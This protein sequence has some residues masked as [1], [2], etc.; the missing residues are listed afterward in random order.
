MREEPPEKT[1]WN[2][3]RSYESGD[4]YLYRMIFSSNKLSKLRDISYSICQ[5]IIKKS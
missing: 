3:L 1:L 2:G 4:L 5:N